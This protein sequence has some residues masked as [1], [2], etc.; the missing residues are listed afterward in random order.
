MVVLIAGLSNTPGQSSVLFINRGKF[1][2]FAFSLVVSA[3]IFA[4]TL[5]AEPLSAEPFTDAN[6][7]AGFQLPL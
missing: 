5:S 6:T 2:R 7:V 3:V 1:S 4:L